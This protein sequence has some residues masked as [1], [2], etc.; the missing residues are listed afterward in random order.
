M[1]ANLVFLDIK[2]VSP[3]Q[4][5]GSWASRVSISVIVCGVSRGKPRKR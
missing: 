2:G 3:R 5:L 4:N 1:Y